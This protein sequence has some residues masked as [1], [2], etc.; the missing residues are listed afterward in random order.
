MGLKL[1]P[2]WTGGTLTLL[3]WGEVGCRVLQ[4]LFEV[5][6]HKIFVSAENPTKGGGMWDLKGALKNFRWD[7]HQH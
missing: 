7:V 6:N 3:I 5:F 4:K 1:R 2:Y